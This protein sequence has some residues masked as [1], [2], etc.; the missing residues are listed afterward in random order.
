[1]KKMV[2]AL[3]LLA[4][5]ASQAASKD[6]IVCSSKFDSLTLTQ[7]GNTYSVKTT[8]HNRLMSQYFSGGESTS[9]SISFDSVQRIEKSTDAIVLKLEGVKSPIA[10]IV[11][12]GSISIDT[13]ASEGEAAL[14]VVQQLKGQ[15]QLPQTGLINLYDSCEVK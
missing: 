11:A 3:S 5:V 13:N 4:S 10:F 1:M 2:L 8:S 7:D 12:G 14:E 9:R 6:L 15:L